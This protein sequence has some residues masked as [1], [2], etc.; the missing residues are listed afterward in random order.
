M[1]VGYALIWLA[2]SGASGVLAITAV[3]QWA[4]V[5]AVIG[6]VLSGAGCVLTLVGVVEVPR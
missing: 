2:V 6:L 3:E 5:L 1:T 4:R